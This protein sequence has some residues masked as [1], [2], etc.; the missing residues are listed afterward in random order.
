MEKK[1]KKFNPITLEKMGQESLIITNFF[2]TQERI[3]FISKIYDFS[4]QYP[5]LNDNDIVQKYLE[6]NHL[7]QSVYGIS[8]DPYLEYKV[9]KMYKTDKN[10]A[11]MVDE[12][13]RTKNEKG[14]IIFGYSSTEQLKDAIDKN[15]GERLELLKLDER[16]LTSEKV[17]SQ[18]VF[19]GSDGYYTLNEKVK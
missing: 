1:L 15:K 14:K 10:F 12:L 9:Y 13:K 7:L 17:K 8:I 16:E 2:V 5:N 3:D 6:E 4:K 11:E 19:V 18:G